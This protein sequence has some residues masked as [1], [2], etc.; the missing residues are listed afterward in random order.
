MWKPSGVRVSSKE[1]S[2]EGVFFVRGPG[3]CR[4]GRKQIR[5]T[6]KEVVA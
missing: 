3:P 4:Y 5:V 2:R 1:G 6:G